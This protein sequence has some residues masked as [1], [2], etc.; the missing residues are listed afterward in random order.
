MLIVGGFKYLTSGGDQKAT[1]SAQQT[2]TFAVVGLVL[3]V[4]AFLVFRLI[5][6][7]TGVNVT[8]FVI[9]QL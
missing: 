9:P 3:L 2:L 8:N 1:A 6:Q 4:L 7:F 5:E